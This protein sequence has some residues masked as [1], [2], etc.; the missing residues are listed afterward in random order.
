[1]PATCR[2]EPAPPRPEWPVQIAWHNHIAIPLTH[3]F[4]EADNI[5]VG[6]ATETDL[7]SDLLE[8][9]GNLF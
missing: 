4:L 7:Q 8:A 9:P 1:M 6:P 5:D 3:P 2:A